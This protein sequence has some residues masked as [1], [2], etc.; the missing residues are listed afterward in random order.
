MPEAAR[1]F[2]KV[3]DLDEHLIRGTSKHV[4]T[5]HLLCEPRHKRNTRATACA[6][7]DLRGNGRRVIARRVAPMRR[8]LVGRHV[9]QDF[10]GPC[11]RLLQA[12]TDIDQGT[13]GEAV[14]GCL[15]IMGEAV[16]G[17]IA[18]V[19]LAN[20][21]VTGE[22]H[23]ASIFVRCHWDC[24]LA[25]ADGDPDGWMGLLVGPRPDVDLAGMEPAAFEIARPIMRGPGLEDHVVG[26][27]QPLRSPER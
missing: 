4:A 11:P 12:V 20:A 6:L 26:F 7:H 1:I 21:R 16:G 9:P 18:V 27:P 22:K 19:D 3:L 10:F 17:T 2:P 23:R 13:I 15:Y 25:T 24:T 5:G 14:D 8:H